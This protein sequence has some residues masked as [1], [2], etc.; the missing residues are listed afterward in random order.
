ML[1]K[2]TTESKCPSCG[3]QGLVISYA[4]S[5]V[6]LMFCKYCHFRPNPDQVDTSQT[7]MAHVYLAH[8]RET[9]PSTKEDKPQ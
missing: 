3:K 1:K 7:Q 5:A 4:P 6:G 9:F 8:A 2:L